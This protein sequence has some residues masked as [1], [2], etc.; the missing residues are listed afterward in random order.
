MVFK[1][2]IKWEYWPTRVNDLRTEIGHCCLYLFPT[3][4]YTMP[5]ERNTSSSQ[6][7]ALLSQVYIGRLSDKI[8]RIYYTSIQKQP[9]KVV[10]EMSNKKLL[11]IWAKLLE[12]LY[13]ERFIFSKV[14]D[15]QGV[16]I[17]KQELL[18]GHFKKKLYLLLRNICFREYSSIATSANIY[19]GDY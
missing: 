16:G 9:S 1:A 18:Y 7:R 19:G 2:E 11:K 15:I 13:K 3:Q 12:T 6:C 4:Y 14:T 10:L 17:L 5:D 8:W